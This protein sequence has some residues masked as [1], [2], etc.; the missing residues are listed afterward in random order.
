M[1]EPWSG[2][3]TVCF[4]PVLQLSDGDRHAA[5]VD[6]SGERLHAGDVLDQLI[7]W[8]MLH[9]KARVSQW[10]H[11]KRG[12]VTLEDDKVAVT[13]EPVNWRTEWRRQARMIRD[14]D[15]GCAV[16]TKTTWG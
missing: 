12:N 2:Q 13:G 1:D 15:V 10:L 16:A 3:L 4:G 11:L 5:Q 6:H 9:L 14:L 8:G 7:R